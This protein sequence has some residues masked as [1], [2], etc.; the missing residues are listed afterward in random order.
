MND[1][2]IMLIFSLIETSLGVNFR[3]KHVIPLDKEAFKKI[4]AFILSDISL[5]VRSVALI[6]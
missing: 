2:G 1:I 3:L 5:L 6:V 4:E